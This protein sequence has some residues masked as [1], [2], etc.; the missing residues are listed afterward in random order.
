VWLLWLGL[1]LV[2]AVL[3]SA[4]APA[5]RWNF[6]NAPPETYEVSTHTDGV[7]TRTPDPG[8][9]FGLDLAGIGRSATDEVRLKGLGRLKSLI[10]LNASFTPIVDEALKEVA[11][12]K[13]LKWLDLRASRVTDAGLKEL[14]GLKNLQALDL[15]WTQ[16][17]DAGVAELQ[18]SLPE[19]K[20]VR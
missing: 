8:M 4:T 17:T 12:L 19:C 3:P 7:L 20:I 5:P 13:N 1:A 2:A 10:W 14:T 11:E 16:V 9:P 15:R 6:P 18:R